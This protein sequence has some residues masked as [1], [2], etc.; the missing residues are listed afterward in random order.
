[1]RGATGSFALGCVYMVQYKMLLGVLSS[2]AFRLQGKAHAQAANLL[3]KTKSWA[4]VPSPLPCSS[5]STFFKW[6]DVL[7]LHDFHLIHD[8]SL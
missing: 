6:R 3:F 4:K 7:S 2:G 8:K 1:M 5:P